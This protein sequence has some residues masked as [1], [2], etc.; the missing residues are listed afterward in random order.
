M[1]ARTPGK[2]KVFPLELSLDM[3]V[4]HAVQVSFLAG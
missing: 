3:R 1:L 2:S 4:L